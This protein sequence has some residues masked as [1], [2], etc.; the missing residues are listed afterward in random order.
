MPM[1]ECVKRW[2][3]V[4]LDDRI[5]TARASH[6]D[7]PG[8][9]ALTQP[10]RDFCLEHFG[11]TLPVTNEK[12]FEMIELWDD[13]AKRVRP[14]TGVLLE[15]VLAKLQMELEDLRRHDSRRRPEPP[16]FS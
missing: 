8:R 6:N 4:G 7:R 3:A 1:V 14:D 11:Q 15:D 16:D 12:D 5:V 13:R 2:L 9:N 10:V